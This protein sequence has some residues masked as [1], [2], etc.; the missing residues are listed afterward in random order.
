MVRGMREEVRP[1]GSHPVAVPLPLCQMFGLMMALMDGS[2]VSDSHLVI[3][4][5]PFQINRL[6]S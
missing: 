6:G 4:L 2:H 1:S 5:G 3:Y